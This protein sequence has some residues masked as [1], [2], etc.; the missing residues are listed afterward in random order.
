MPFL[1]AAIA[2]YFYLVVLTYAFPLVKLAELVL[3]VRH[4]RGVNFHRQ[5]EQAAKRAVLRPVGL[6]YVFCDVYLQ[7]D[8]RAAYQARAAARAQRIAEAKRDA[9]SR[10]AAL[11]DDTLDAVTV[12]VAGGLLVG[13]VVLAARNVGPEHHTWWGWLLIGVPLAALFGLVLFA[14]T[15]WTLRGFVGAVRW[16]LWLTSRMSRQV[17]VAVPAG[18]VGLAGALALMLG[19][20]AVRHAIAEVAVFLIPCAIV[21]G[22]GGWLTLRTHG[23]W[24]SGR[25]RWKCDVA[26]APLAPTA[27]A[28]IVTL[29]ARNTLVAQATVALLF[30]VAVWLAVRTWRAMNASSQVAVRAFANIAAS[31]VLGLALLGLLVWL[32]NELHMPPAEVAAIRRGL[33]VTGKLADRPAWQWLSLYALLAAA[34]VIFATR[35]AGLPAVARWFTRLRIVPAVTASQRVATVA[36]IGLLVAAVI[37]AATPVAV[38]SGLK[39]RLS[40]RYTETLAENLREHGELSAYTAIQNAFSTKPGQVQVSSLHNMLAEIDKA[41]SP[42]S[43][44]APDAGA[45]L[46][47]AER[48][49]ELPAIVQ[50]AVEVT[51]RDGLDTPLRDADDLSERISKLEHEQTDKQATAEQV[52]KAADLAAKAIGAA[53]QLPDLGNFEIVSLIKEYLSGLVENSPVKDAFAGWVRRFADARPPPPVAEIVVPDGPRLKRAAVAALNAELV[54]IAVTDP[55]VLAKLQNES[56]DVASAV[57]VTNATRHLQGQSGPCHNCPDRKPPAEEPGRPVEPEP[58]VP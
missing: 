27:A 51:H 25:G 9:R 35:P 28:A 38:A 22:I 43:D 40:E 32:A 13:C 57:D 55:A 30:P 29:G 36:H 46:H 19:L 18:L 20:G 23:R 10:L 16:S 56:D 45:A 12:Y 33:H 47:L 7:D 14:L 4:G 49:G 44:Q 24:H 6:Y 50:A 39:A 41:S 21:T 48:M 8:L 53:V 31:L 17:R 52:D 15:T 1:G 34:S 37:G 58:M 11:T 5:C 2:S 3:L 42:T 54:D 26:Y